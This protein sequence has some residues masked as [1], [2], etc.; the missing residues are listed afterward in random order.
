M[1]RALIWKEYREHRWT[2]V[3]FWA[4]LV[5]LKLGLGALYHE[6]IQ[7]NTMR[8]ENVGFLGESRGGSALFSRRLP[9]GNAGSQRARRFRVG[10]DHHVGG[11]S[12]SE[13]FEFHAH[14]VRMLGPG[15]ALQQWILA[16]TSV[17]CNSHYRGRT[18][19]YQA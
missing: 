13:R 6:A 19:Q 5:G 12:F 2:L 15:F 18:R 3:G 17:W 1:I 8:Y 14:A 16:S 7:H 10:S 9:G 11:R 4:A